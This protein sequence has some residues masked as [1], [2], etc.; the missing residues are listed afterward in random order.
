MEEKEWKTR[1]FKKNEKVTVNE[2]KEWINERKN[3]R[4]KENESNE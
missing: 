4:I 1:A 2:G 3:N